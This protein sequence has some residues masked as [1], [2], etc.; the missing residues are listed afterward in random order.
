MYKLID[1]AS[2]FSHH[3]DYE[4]S[5]QVINFDNLGELTK[6]A[7]DER[8]HAFVKA[9]QPQPGRIYI[10]INA[11][12]AGEY[13]SANKN[14]DWFPEE[15]L[16]QYYKTFET[17]P[18]HVF[19]HHINKDPAKSIG[20]VI[21]ALYNDRMHRIELIAE[22]DKSLGKDIEDRLAAGDFPLTSMAAKTPFDICSICGNKAHTRQEYCS[23]LRSELGQL[24]P[25]GRRVMAS[26]LAHLSS[27]TLALLLDRLMLQAVSYKKSLL[28][29]KLLVLLNWRN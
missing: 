15:N 18:A 9:I 20:R 17:S 8:I 29:M 1:T 25:D 4:P 3:K 24:L 5:V 6:E 28:K 12:G 2:F 13:W 11:M 21:F 22:V 10:H 27:L 14:G 26:T 19:R 23:H 7:A 16:K